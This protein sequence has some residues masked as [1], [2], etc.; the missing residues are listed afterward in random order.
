[1]TGGCAKCRIAG[2]VG[3]AIYGRGKLVVSL[4]KK[5]VT[6]TVV[7]KQIYGRFIDLRYYEQRARERELQRL[8]ERVDRPARQ[9]HRPSTSLRFRF[10]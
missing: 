1:M 4:V 6:E 7:G 3:S 10:Y 2:I 9:D 5:K 8:K